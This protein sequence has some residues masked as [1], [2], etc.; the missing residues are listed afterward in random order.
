MP[1]FR[2][3]VP[4]SKSGIIYQFKEQFGKEGSPMIVN[5]MEESL[6]GNVAAPENLKAKTARIYD[7]YFGD[8]TNERE[9]ARLLGGRKSAE[10]AVINRC[11]EHSR[12]YPDISG[13]V[14]EKFKQKHPNF[15][16]ITG[17]AK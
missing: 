8:I 10:A 12:K 3:Y 7:L 13:D 2:V 5:F 6:T 4:E 1:E 14:I 9:F 11:A 17:V 15:A 16:K